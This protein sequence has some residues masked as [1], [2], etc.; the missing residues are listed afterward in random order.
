MVAMFT[1]LIEIRAVHDIVFCTGISVRPAACRGNIGAPLFIH[2]E[3]SV[4]GGLC[5]KELE[6]IRPFDH[7]QNVNQLP[8]QAKPSDNLSPVSGTT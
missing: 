1:N 3:Q 2:E 8:T 7:L 5:S 6:G 4:R